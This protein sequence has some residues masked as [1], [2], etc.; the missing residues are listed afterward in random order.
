[1]I[2]TTPNI[3]MVT[4]CSIS[5][6]AC[7]VLLWSFYK[8]NKKLASLKMIVILNI[9]DFM[10]SLL[11]FLWALMYNLDGT[12]KP[13]LIMIFMFSFVQFSIIWSCN[14]ARFVSKSIDGNEILD[15][16]KYFKNSLVFSI[17][18]TL[19]LDLL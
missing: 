8:T 7:L 16:N 13:L 6:L 19:A 3:V 12:E 10:I 15:Q 11:A 2:A 5:M 1:M 9:S 14:I 18:L 4:S 17:A